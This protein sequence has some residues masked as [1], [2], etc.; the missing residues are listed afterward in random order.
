MLNQIKS[1]VILA[2]AASAFIFVS[3]ISAIDYGKPSA[4]PAVATRAPQASSQGMLKACQARESAIKTRMTHLTQLA[5]DMI[6]NFDTH[7]T[8]VEDYYTTKVLPSGKKVSNYDSLVS[9]IAAKKTAVS[10]ALTK[11]QLDTQGFNCSTGNPKLEMTQFRTDMQSVKQALKDFRTSIKNLIV[12]I[13]SVTGSEATS[14]GK[15]AK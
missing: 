3:P 6:N 2:I 1:S 7:V 12:A 15:E 8:K 5:T 11:T 10:S 13:H 4:V 14:S 9:D